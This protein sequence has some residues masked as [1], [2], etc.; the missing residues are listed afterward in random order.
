[1]QIEDS[2]VYKD[3]HVEIAS[4]ATK[5]AQRFVV[6]C[7]DKANF[8]YTITNENSRKNVALSGSQIREGPSG[9]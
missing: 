9:A 2:S 5:N 8:V 1:M 4:A 6:T 7:V 3:A